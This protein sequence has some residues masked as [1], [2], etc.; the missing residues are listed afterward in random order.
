MEHRYVMAR[1]IKT[2][3]EQGF[4]KDVS[5]SEDYYDN[6]SV[7]FPFVNCDVLDVFV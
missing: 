6:S 2:L 3:Y 1:R 5:I 7:T 4:L